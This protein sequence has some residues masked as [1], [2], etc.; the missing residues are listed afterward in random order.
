MCVYVYVYVPS[1]GG[2][3]PIFYRGGKTPRWGPKTGTLGVAAAVVVG[4]YV[5]ICDGYVC[6]CILSVYMCVY[7]MGMCVYVYICVYMCVYVMGIC[8]YVMGICLYVMGIC[9]CAYV[10]WYVCTC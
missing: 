5:M 6:M 1:K 3:P 8:L 7:V 4:L 10:H 9:V 2:K